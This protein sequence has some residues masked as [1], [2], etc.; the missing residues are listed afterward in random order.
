MRSA[1]FE[2]RNFQSGTDASQSCVLCFYIYSTKTSKRSFGG[3]KAPTFRLSRQPALRIGFVRARYCKSI[4]FSILF[5]S[6]LSFLIKRYE[7]KTGKT[8]NH[9]RKDPMFSVVGVEMKTPIINA[10]AE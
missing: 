4:R 6:L 9:I 1:E 7:P 3:L 5:S 8:N 10:V 2:S